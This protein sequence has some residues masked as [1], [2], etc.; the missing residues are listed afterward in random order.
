M[1]KL[2]IKKT[3]HHILATS[4]NAP[5][6]VQAATRIDLVVSE[7]AKNTITRTLSRHDSSDA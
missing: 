3:K 7:H 1:Q 4:T 2:L 6:K 5:G